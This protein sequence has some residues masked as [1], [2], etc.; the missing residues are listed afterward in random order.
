MGRLSKI[1]R[2]Q[3][4]KVAL[5][6]L[7]ALLVVLCVATVI[8]YGIHQ[9]KWGYW[10]GL[11]ERNAGLPLAELPLRVCLIT[12]SGSAVAAGPDGSR[13]LFRQGRLTWTCC[14]LRCCSASWRG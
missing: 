5:T 6:V 2:E 14:G 9:K 11:L 13:R 3:W 7:L 10:Y 1:S 8:S 12:S 4:T